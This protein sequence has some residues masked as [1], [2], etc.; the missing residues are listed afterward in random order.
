MFRKRVVRVCS[1]LALSHTMDDSGLI[2]N[3]VLLKNGYLG[4]DPCLRANVYGHD[5]CLRVT[6]GS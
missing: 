4:H 2:A 3:F 6:S 1:F 5:P